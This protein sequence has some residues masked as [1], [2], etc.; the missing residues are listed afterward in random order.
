MTYTCFDVSHDNGIAHIQ[1]SRPEK[2]NSMILEF[3]DELP[4]LVREIDRD[5]KTKVIVI[6]STGPHF[7]AGLDL[8]AFA[9]VTAHSE[10][11]NEVHAH[12]TKGLGFYQNVLRM[13]DCFTALEKARVPV[14]VAIQGGCIG[15]GVDMV[16]ACDMRYCTAD[17]FFT[18]Y[19]INIGMTA[20]VGTF[21]RI[22]NHLPEGV[23]RELSYTGRRM[24]A[25]E[26]KSLGLVNAVYETQDAMLEGVMEVAREIA[27]KPPMAI[28]G[29]KNIITYAR[30]HSTDDTLDY[31]GIWN[32]TML[33]QSEVMEAMKAK[34]TG[35]PGDFAPL[36]P[37]RKVAG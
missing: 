2:R 35:E 36:P 8:A 3:W 24:S 37:F 34:Q 10:A 17:A 25:E 11:S 19:E 26:A 29:C 18:I 16:T 6:S 22:L 27:T 33:Q 9:N 4:E 32:A 7:T 5:G 21:P 1:L 23:V 15:G 20:D 30:D 12:A 13:Q 31:I 28:Y 14:L